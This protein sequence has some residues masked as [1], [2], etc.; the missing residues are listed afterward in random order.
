MIFISNCWFSQ[1]DKT[2]ISFPSS[3]IKH[4]F[5]TILCDARKEREKKIQSE[6]VTAADDL[7]NV[8]DTSDDMLPPDDDDDDHL[9]V[10]IKPIKLTEITQIFSTEHCQHC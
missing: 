1:P 10:R 9:L 6:D 7:E 4:T 2:Q 3:H 8:D 5:S